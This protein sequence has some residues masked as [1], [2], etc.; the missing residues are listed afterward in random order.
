[1]GTETAYQSLSHHPFDR[2]RNEKRFD[3]HVDH[4]GIRPGGIVGMKGTENQMAGQRGLD[5]ILGRFE[6][7]NFPDKDNIGVVTQ[8]GA[9]ACVERQPNLGMNL[10]LINAV[11]LVFNRVFGR[12]DFDIVTLDFVERAVKVVV[13]PLPSGR[14]Q[15]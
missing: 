15:G 9:E 2:R 4:A 10:N 1:M 14:S 3:T 6:V 13:F 5:C 11:E 7:T 8:D 12:D